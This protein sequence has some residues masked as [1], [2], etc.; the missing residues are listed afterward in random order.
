MPLL[1]TMIHAGPRARPSTGARADASHGPATCL[2]LALRGFPV[3]ERAAV[4]YLAQRH[5]LWRALLDYLPAVEPICALARELL[6]RELYPGPALARLL[7]AARAV[8]L[9]DDPETRAAFATARHAA[10]AQL[11]PADPDGLLCDR[12]LADLTEIELGRDAAV[13][14]I[15]VSRDVLRYSHYVTT[16]RLHYDA[17]HAAE[18]AALANV[19][20]DVL[21]RAHAARHPRAGLLDL[22][23]DA[24]R[25]ALGRFDLR[26]GLSFS[27]CAA[28][29]VRQALAR[30]ADALPRDPESAARAARRLA[31][32]FVLIHG[33]SPAA[34]EL[35]WLR[36]PGGVRRGLSTSTAAPPTALHGDLSPHLV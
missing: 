28:W 6:A 15:R 10:A 9:H 35:A 18:A 22:A 16:V 14:P 26:R 23:E 34:G 27:V 25:R 5:A 2:R 7:A 19:S 11:G 24:L 21:I 33:R 20:L 12:L 17:L 3:D 13:V 30:A 29:W 31:H 32:E 4:R 8:R 1:P 36:D